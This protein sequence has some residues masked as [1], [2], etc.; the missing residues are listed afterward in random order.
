MTAG[1]RRATLDHT[2]GSI[3]VRAR[4]YLMKHI[5][6]FTSKGDTVATVHSTG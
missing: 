6:I 4:S 2:R 5:H 1:G 3:R